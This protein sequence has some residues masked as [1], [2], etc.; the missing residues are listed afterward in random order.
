MLDARANSEGPERAPWR[1]VGAQEGK[2]YVDLGDAAWRAVGITPH[3]WS[4]LEK[5]DLPFI[6]SPRMRPLCEPE[7]GSSI[8][9][10]RAFANIATEDD[11]LI[12]V[13]WLVA[14]LRERGPYPILVLNGEQGSGKSSFSRLLRSLIDPASP[15]IQ[16]PPKDEQNLIVTAQNGHLIIF[17]NLSHI[18]AELSDGLCRLAT[19]SGF[20]VRA[21]HTDKDDNIFDGAR[22]IAVNG[23][24]ALAERAD[25][26]ERCVT[27]RLASIPEDRR[28]PED[29]IERDWNI[30]R[31]R[32]LGALYDAISSALRN[33]GTTRLARSSRM[34][35]FEKWLAA[36][37]PGL[38]WEAGSFSAAYERRRRDSQSAAFESDVVAVAIEDFMTR[39]HARVWSGTATELL[40][41][42]SG[43]V[44]EQVRQ[45]RIWPKTAQGLGNC[46]ERSIPVLRT[47]GILVDRRHSGVRTITISRVA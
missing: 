43:N 40:G 6:R 27:A 22:P 33:I 11:F 20:A 23:I 25:L 44:G 15:A 17:D 37:E 4:V 41:Q 28:R 32:I 39:D 45:M 35:D 7:A 36:A 1:R 18:G 46:I 19:G 47:K 8:D 2:L 12:V 31:P 29:E 5:H 24:P 42:L 14:A 34:A 3:G 9:E 38:G 26:A 21:L 13:A 16:G 30:A 10:L